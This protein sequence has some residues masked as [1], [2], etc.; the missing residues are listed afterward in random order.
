LFSAL[1]SFLLG[2][3]HT[4]PNE[5][6]SSLPSCFSF[7]VLGSFLLPFLTPQLQKILFWLLCQVLQIWF[8]F[9]S[10]ALPISPARDL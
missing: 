6:I 2:S 4:I 9:K 1:R 5:L 8:F 3:F 7:S 10:E